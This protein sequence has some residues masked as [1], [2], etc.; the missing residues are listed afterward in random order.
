MQLLGLVLQ[1]YVTAAD[2]EMTKSMLE[3]GGGV[4]GAIFTEALLEI[5][6]E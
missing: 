1:R 2:G 4:V 3:A 6:Q 5:S